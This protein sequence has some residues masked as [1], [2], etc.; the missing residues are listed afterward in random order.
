MQQLHISYIYVDGRLSESLPQAGYYIY[1][2]ETP[3]PERIS[4]GAISKFS[5]VAGL[6]AV[7][8]HGPVT[9]YD[10]FGLGVKQELDGFTGRHSM[11]VGRFGDFLVGVAV[12]ALVFSFSRSILFNRSLRWL[13]TL[14]RIVAS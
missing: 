11:G 2:G 10:T 3:H 9:I 4:A 8:H 12:S 7:Y 5:H 6:V 1:P 14:S 13:V